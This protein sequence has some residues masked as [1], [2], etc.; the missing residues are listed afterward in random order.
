MSN[1]DQTEEYRRVCAMVLERDGWRCQCCGA[2]EN[3]QVHH[4]QFRSQGG[5]DVPDNLIVLCHR[6]HRTRHSG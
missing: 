1:S 2:M 3:L 4:Q 5:P 6:C